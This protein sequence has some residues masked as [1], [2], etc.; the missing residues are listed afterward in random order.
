ME[1]VDVGCDR[2]AEEQLYD[3]KKANWVGLRKVGSFI[4]K[5]HWLGWR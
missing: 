3:A 1:E 5:M 2:L 4:K